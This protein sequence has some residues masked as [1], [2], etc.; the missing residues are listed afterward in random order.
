MVCQELTHNFYLYLNN[1]ENSM[2]TGNI[3]ELDTLY[4][5]K[6][7][8]TVDDEADIFQPK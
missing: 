5:E 8:K 1:L 2:Q 3:R 4:I 7:F 6:K